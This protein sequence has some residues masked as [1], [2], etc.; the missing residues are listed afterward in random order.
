[1]SDCGDEFLLDGRALCRRF[2]RLAFAIFAAVV[3]RSLLIEGAPIIIRL[4]RLPG[5][6]IFLIVFGLFRRALVNGYF[7]FVIGFF[8]VGAGLFRGFIGFLLAL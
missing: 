6:Q 1:M 2:L 7:F 4:I 8:I 5:K 3:G